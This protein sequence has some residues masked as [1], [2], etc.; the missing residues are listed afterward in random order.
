MFTGGFS[1][2]VLRLDVHPCHTDGHPARRPAW[3]AVVQELSAAPRL[4]G[5]PISVDPQ[6]TTGRKTRP[7]SPARRSGGGECLV[8]LDS[9][10]L[11]LHRQHESGSL[12]ATAWSR[13]LVLPPQAGPWSRPPSP[14]RPPPFPRKWAPHPWGLTRQPAPLLGAKRWGAATS[15]RTGAHEPLHCTPS[16][17]RRG[18]GTAAPAPTCS[19]QAC[20][21]SRIHP[22]NPR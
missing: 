15:S 1:H 11:G 9:W 17:C 19:S 14:P 12:C 4:H 16:S 20:R 18:N 21:P 10:P 5:S 6:A 22:L 2:R 13:R 7:A 8:M 3:W